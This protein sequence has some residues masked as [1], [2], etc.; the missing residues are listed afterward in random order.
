MKLNNIQQLPSFRILTSQAIQNR[1]L[2]QTFL[3]I[4]LYAQNYQNSQ[5]DISR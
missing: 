5:N 4:V 3:K 2:H 1:L